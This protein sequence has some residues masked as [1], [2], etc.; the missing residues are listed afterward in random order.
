MRCGARWTRCIVRRCS[1]RRRT[2]FEKAPAS[3]GGGYK[4][5]GPRILGAFLLLRAGTVK[6]MRLQN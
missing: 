5:K 2:F 3:E 6:A 1:E 4:E